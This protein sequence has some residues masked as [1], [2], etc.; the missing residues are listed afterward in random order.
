MLL[1]LR[2]IDGDVVEAWKKSFQGL[3]NVEISQGDIFDIEAVAI[4]SPAN[5]FGYMDGGIDLVYLR[6]FGW[7]LQ[8]RLQQHITSAHDGELPV[9]QATILETFDAEIPFL[10]SA[11][12]MRVPMTVSKTLNAYLALRAAIRAVKHYN[13]EHEASIRSV[14]CPG[15]CTA[16]GRMPP[17]LAARQMAQA[18]RTCVLGEHIGPSSQQKLLGA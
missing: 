13:L 1:Y 17:G 10:I 8:G 12:T 2:D 4:V 15:L 14:L 5:S 18:Y 11:P 9:G 7:E 6:R 16:I 3:D